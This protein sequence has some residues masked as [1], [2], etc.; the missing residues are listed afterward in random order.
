MPMRT[1]WTNIYM[2]AVTSIGAGICFVS[3]INLTI[4]DIDI[5]FWL[6][7][8]ATV[9]MGSRVAVRIPRINTNITVEDTFLFM[10][11][12]LYGGNAATLLGILAGTCSGLRISKRPRTVLFAAGSLACAVFGTSQ[13]LVLVFG[14]SSSVVNGSMATVVKAIAVIGLSQ[15]FLHTGLVAIANALKDNQPVWQ[16]WHQNFLWISVT[17]F[18][19]A[20]AEWLIVRILVTAGF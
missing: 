4:G 2:W 3:I 10:A 11:L 6:L 17:N 7:A 9:L 16:M 15:Y 12:L 1:K 20:A 19:G 8:L 18:R 14:S 5:Y 13:V